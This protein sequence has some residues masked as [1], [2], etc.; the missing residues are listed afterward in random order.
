LWENK[1]YSKILRVV[2]ILLS[3]LLCCPYMASF[4]NKWTWI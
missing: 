4:I 1:F 2:Y 3:Q